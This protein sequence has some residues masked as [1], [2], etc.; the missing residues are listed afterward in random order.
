MASVLVGRRFL[1]KQQTSCQVQH[2]LPL[3]LSI[4][5]CSSNN[6]VPVFDNHSNLFSANVNRAPDLTL[7]CISGSEIVEQ[8][9]TDDHNTAPPSPDP[10]LI[11]ISL[12]EAIHQP[13]PGRLHF[14]SPRVPQEV[15]DRIW[16]HLLV[17]TRFVRFQRFGATRPHTGAK[18]ELGLV[19]NTGKECSSEAF[20]KSQEDRRV[21]SVP[22]WGL[23]PV[24]ICAL[25][26][27]Q[28]ETD[29]NLIPKLP[30]EL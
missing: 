25:T 21:D 6:F 17:E 23:D 15:R 11:R 10:P 1:Y 9:S 27:V 7:N 5:N 28:F 18:V 12:S 26:D 19:P 20:A 8:R 2:T 3:I 4:Q 30:L 24:S 13:S 16:Y 22:I 29:S 14:Y